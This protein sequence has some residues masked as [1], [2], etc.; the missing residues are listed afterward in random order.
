MQI[1]ANPF[2]KGEVFPTWGVDR[3]DPLVL[4]IHGP[5]KTDSARPNG[6]VRLLE[7]SSGPLTDLF[8]HPITAAGPQRVALRKNQPFP[9]AVEESDAEMGASNVNR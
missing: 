1:S 3:G 8:K 2:G 5:T 4:E 9:L 6:R 7:E